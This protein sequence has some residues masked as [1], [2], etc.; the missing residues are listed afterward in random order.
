MTPQPIVTQNEIIGYLW[1]VAGCQ[2]E[3]QAQYAAAIRRVVSGEIEAVKDLDR[4]YDEAE[5][6]VGLAVWL[7]QT[8]AH[9]FDRPP[10]KIIGWW[11]RAILAYQCLRYGYP[12]R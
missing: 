9:D 3:R 10:P 1:R 7:A 2:K 5:S 11:G 8:A 6:Q 4:I 12:R